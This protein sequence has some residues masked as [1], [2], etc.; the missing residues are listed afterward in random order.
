MSY[1]MTVLVKG[2]LVK[3]G[4]LGHSIYKSKV[5]SKLGAVVGCSVI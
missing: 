1:Q 2:G 4:K 3:F 5:V